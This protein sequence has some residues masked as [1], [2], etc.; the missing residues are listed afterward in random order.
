MQNVNIDKCLCS[1]PVASEEH[2]M[3][4]SSSDQ[5]EEDC[6]ARIRMIN[7]GAHPDVVQ[8]QKSKTGQYI[9]EVLKKQSNGSQTQQTE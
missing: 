5:S 3:H 1:Y 6:P 2:L 4:F 7:D 8:L 9:Q